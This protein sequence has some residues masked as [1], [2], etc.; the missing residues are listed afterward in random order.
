MKKLLRLL[1]P[2]ILMSSSLFGGELEI[3]VPTITSSDHK[4]LKHLYLL[5]KKATLKTEE[6]DG[7][8]LDYYLCTAYDHIHVLK[9]KIDIK[10]SGWSSTSFMFGTFLATI[11]TI[12]AGC[13]L[14]INEL[15]IQDKLM[16]GLLSSYLPL[17]SPLFYK[18]AH[19]QQRLAKRL[20]RN[21]RIF[22]LLQAEWNL[23]HSFTN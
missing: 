11:G 6:I 18:A 19:Y 14:I 16:L 12:S 2:L 3:D 22:R 9:H 21:K 7:V 17:S 20:R 13:L 5:D 15:R 8:S 4:A 10:K 23:R 1:L